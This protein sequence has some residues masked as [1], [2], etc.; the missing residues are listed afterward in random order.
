MRIYVTPRVERLRDPG[1]P[2]RGYLS[3]EGEF[4]EDSLDWR[5]FEAAGDVTISDGPPSSSQTT[6]KPA[7]KAA[8]SP[9]AKEA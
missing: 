1:D 8:A 7:S 3:A 5:R 9:A 2:A 6:A 4:R